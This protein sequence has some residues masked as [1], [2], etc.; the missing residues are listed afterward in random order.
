MRSL[1][2]I[3]TGLFFACFV[4]SCDNG[5]TLN[6]FKPVAHH[7][8]DKQTEFLFS[9]AV[10][11][12]SVPYDIFL[13]LRNNNTYP[14]QNIW[15][16]YKELSPSSSSIASDTVEYLL[17]DDFGKWTGNGITLFQNRLPIK[18]QYLFPDTGQYVISLRHGMRDNPL[19]GIENVGLYIR[20]SDP[21][22]ASGIDAQENK[23]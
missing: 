8:W 12:A 19:K 22:L 9:V 11:D 15:V 13:Q 23:Q 1:K 17:A 3:V 20:P 18:R 14:Y 6:E 21:L 5:A 2:H 7:R 16:F 4:Y 10:R